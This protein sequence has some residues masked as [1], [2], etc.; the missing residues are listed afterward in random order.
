[1]GKLLLPD[2]RERRKPMSLWRRYNADD[3]LHNMNNE[4]ISIA[5]NIK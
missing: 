1:M 2:Y 4:K 5:K 3:V